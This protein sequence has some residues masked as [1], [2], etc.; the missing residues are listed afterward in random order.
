MQKYCDETYSLLVKSL[1]GYSRLLCVA[2]SHD[3][4]KKKGQ[5]KLS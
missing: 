5:V 3:T 4:K 1:W 2:T